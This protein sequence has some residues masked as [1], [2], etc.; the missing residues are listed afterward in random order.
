MCIYYIFTTHDIIIIMYLLVCNMI[1]YVCTSMH[2]ENFRI[3]ARKTLDIM[4][5]R[6]Q[7]FFVV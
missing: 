6:S 2:G 3:C 5:K 1:M 4:L 7:R